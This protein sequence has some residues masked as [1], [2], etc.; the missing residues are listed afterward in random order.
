MVATLLH[1][2]PKKDARVECLA[3]LDGEKSALMRW[4]V[5]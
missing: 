2:Y 5:V 4:M 3:S 1:P